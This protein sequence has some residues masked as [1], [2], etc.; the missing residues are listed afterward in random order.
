[1]AVKQWWVVSG[2]IALATVVGA[3]CTGLHNDASDTSDS[4]SNGPMRPL[5]PESDA[6]SASDACAKTQGC[7][8]RCSSD[9][10]CTQTGMLCDRSAGE[11]VAPAPA[12]PDSGRDAAAVADAAPVTDGSADAAA[13]QTD[14]GPECKSVALDLVRLIPTVMLVVDASGSMQ[15][16]FSLDAGGSASVSRW[17]ALRAALVDPGQGVV[18]ARQG[19][20]RFGS[21]VFGSVPSCPTP[22]GIVSPALDNAAAIAAQLP[23]SLGNSNSDTPSG[24]ALAMVIDRLPDPTV[25]AVGPQIIVLATEGEPNS[26][27]GDGGDAL[28]AVIAAAR[29]AQAKHQKLYVVSVGNP[30]VPDYLQQLANLGAGLAIEARPGAKL[31]V[32]GDPAALT[33]ALA[34]I[35]DAAISCDFEISGRRLEP[36]AE[37]TGRVELNGAALACKGADGWSLLDAAHVRLHGAACDALKAQTARLEASFPCDAVAAP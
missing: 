35:V 29:A 12:A 17:E 25:S 37:C 30:I 7:R 34:A 15:E 6:A 4:G 22:Y 36:G 3:A 31:H 33:S 18:P 32:P 8:A 2:C 13:S 1:L 28:T 24:A 23:V 20:V 27:A 9:L 11:C 14:A 16:S 10:D 5:A 19:A 21:V 26:C